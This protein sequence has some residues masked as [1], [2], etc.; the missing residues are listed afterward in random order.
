[1]RGV[2]AQGWSALR[3]RAKIDREP[4]VSIFLSL[5]HTYSMDVDQTA[6]G[7]MAYINSEGLLK[8]DKP[9]RVVSICNLDIFYFPFDEQNCTL[10]FSSFIYTGK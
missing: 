1:M 3:K 10:T 4:T 9:M 8:Y 2:G 6:T 5:S 7:L